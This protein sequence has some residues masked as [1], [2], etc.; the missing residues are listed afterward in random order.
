MNRKIRIEAGTVSANIGRCIGTDHSPGQ[1]CVGTESFLIEKIAPAPDRLTQR[2]VNDQKIKY[3]RNAFLLELR[4]YINRQNGEK[5]SA[6]N[7]KA[8][9]PDIENRYRIGREFIPGRSDIV[10]PGTD[11]G[12]RDDHNTNIDHVVRLKSEFG[13][14][15]HRKPDA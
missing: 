13:C 7:R 3:R 10:Q 2:Y 4:Q 14:L 15:P 6:Q 8:A 12:R 9:V 5:H 11:D 1:R